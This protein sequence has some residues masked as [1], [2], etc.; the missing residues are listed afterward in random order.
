MVADHATS[1]F[2]AVRDVQR[3]QS[4]DIMFG[5][6]V[7]R[8]YRSRLEEDSK[9]TKGRWKEVQAHCDKANEALKTL[10]SRHQ[11]C[12]SE[13]DGWKSATE[14]KKTAIQ[15]LRRRSE[16]I[17]DQLQQKE[18]SIQKSRHTL[19]TLNREIAQFR[20][21]AKLYRTMERVRIAQA[22]VESYQ[23][24]LAREQK[25]QEHARAK[26]YLFAHRLSRHYLIPLLST[27]SYAGAQLPWINRFFAPVVRKS[28]KR[29]T[30][31]ATTPTTVFPQDGLSKLTEKLKKTEAPLHILRGKTGPHLRVPSPS[32]R[33]NEAPFQDTHEDEGQTADSCPVDDR[34]FHSM[35]QLQLPQISQFIQQVE[36]SLQLAEEKQT[37]IQ[38]GLKTDESDHSALS[39]QIHGMSCQI[40]RHDGHLE[41]MTQ[42]ANSCTQEAGQLTQQHQA[43]LQRQKTSMEELAQ[44][45]ASRALSTFWLDQLHDTAT[46]KGPFITHCRA[47]HVHSLNALIAQA[48][49]ELNQ[50]SEGL[51]TQRLAFQLKPDYTLEPLPGAL[52]MGKRSRGQRTRTYLALFLA[53]FQHTRV[54]L[55]FRTSFVFLDEVMDALDLHG[56]EALQRW[57]QRYV[58]A[59]DVQA[60][61]LTHRET[62]LRGKVIEVVRDRKRGTLYRLRQEETGIGAL[63]VCQDGYS[64]AHFDHIFARRAPTMM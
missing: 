49:D 53:L 9:E 18:D 19:E 59:R 35:D 32:P 27:I 40:A 41:Q 61:L 17:Q 16:E 62:S 29:L 64:F 51:T 43:S 47:R 1:A 15:T 22:E 60:F 28:L 63:S 26:V 45:E 48:L 30:I 7:L 31:W 24:A 39:Q 21:Q 55:P 46:Q 10:A 36:E 56:I 42:Q 6:D 33:H 20:H 25:Q 8:E 57:L 5:L 37:R 52:S 38:A 14:C 3:A 54:G 12:A 2:L 50:D 11:K 34:A 23:V 13:L 58:A 44:V 4:L